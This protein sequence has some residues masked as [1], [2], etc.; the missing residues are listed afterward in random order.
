LAVR[1]FRSLGVADTAEIKILLADGS[2]ATFANGAW[3]TT[4]PNLAIFDG[5]F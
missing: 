3:S 2:T 5:T 1:E 4:I